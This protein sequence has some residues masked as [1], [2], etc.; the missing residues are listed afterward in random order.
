VVNNRNSI[1]EAINHARLSPQQERLWK[2]QQ[3][4]IGQPYRTYCAIMIETAVDRVALKCSIQETIARHQALNTCFICSADS[5]YPQPTVSPAYRPEISEH[6]LS[7]LPQDRRKLRVEELTDQIKSAAFDYERGHLVH[8]ALLV[9]SPQKTLIVLCC[10]A[11]A[12]DTRSLANLMA[13]IWQCYNEQEILQP[14]VP[15]AE[16]A[17]IFQ[18]LL[19]SA[20]T[21]LGRS[22]WTDKQPGHAS[23]SLPF[24]VHS[25]EA[26]EFN[27]QSLQVELDSF[28]LQNIRKMAEASDVSVEAVLL[29]CWCLVLAL[30]SDLEDLQIGLGCDGRTH[31]SLESII[32][33]C[34]RVVPLQLAITP[35]LSVK[36]LVFEVQT[37]INEARQWQDYFG[38]KS[39]T[40]QPAFFAMS[41]DYQKWLIGNAVVEETFSLQTVASYFDP[42]TVKLSCI[43]TAQKLILQFHYDI[44]SLNAENMGR[45][46]RYYFALLQH[47]AAEPRTSIGQL[48]LLPEAER[49]QLLCEFGC[50]IES[51]PQ[52]GF[53]HQY[54]EQQ[55]ARTP[56]SPALL[57]EST[58]LSYCELN[59][60]ANQ[61]ARYLR[62]LGAGVESIIGIFLEPSLEMAIAVL[63]VLK[64]GAAYLPL[65]TA[66]PD[67]RLWLMLEDAGPL[68]VL[69]SSVQANRLSQKAN[70]VVLDEKQ[71]KDTLEQY[72]GEN[73]ALQ[74]ASAL[75]A[76]NLS[77]VIYTSG[78]TGLPKGVMIE[79]AALS[80][81]FHAIGEEIKFS[82]ADIQLWL[83]T[84]SFDISILELLF[85][86]C[87]GARVVI[88][89]KDDGVNPSTMSRLITTSGVTS[90][91]STPSRWSLLIEEKPECLENIRILCGG[92]VLTRKLAKQ[93]CRMAK[94]SLFNLYGPTEATIWAALHKLGQ[95][96]LEGDDGATIAIGRALANCNLYV[97]DSRLQLCPVGV[98]GELYIG[99]EQLARGYI[100]RPELTAARFIP[101]PFSG[102]G[103]RMYRT[104]D[105]ACWNSNGA[106]QFL[107]RIDDQI[108]IRGFRIE[109]AEIESV[110]CRHPAIA[111]AV[112]IARDGDAG[113]KQLVAYLVT[114]EDTKGASREHEAE[115]L[116]HWSCLFEEIARQDPNALVDEDFRIWKSSYDAEAIPLEEMREWRSA[117]V[118]RILELHPQNL[119]EIG[120]GSGLILRKVATD[121]QS[122]W[123]TDFSKSTLEKLQTV[124]AGD[125]V[126]RN[127]VRLELR[128]AHDTEGLPTDFFDVIALNSVIQ[129]FPSAYYLVE[130]LARLLAL[131][132]SGG[133][134]FLGDVRNL[135]LH[136]CFL[137][138]L[139][140]RKAKPGTGALELERRVA[141][142]MAQE[143]ELL[144]APE[145]FA[146]LEDVLPEIGAVDIQ[147]KRGWSHNE[148]TRYRYE[149]VLHKKP[150][151]TYSAREVISFSWE[152]DVKNLAGLEQLLMVQ[153]M[154]ELR[155]AGVPNARTKQEFTVFQALKTAKDTDQLRDML[156]STS[157]REAV[158]PEAICELGQKL[159]YRVAITWSDTAA[160]TGSFDVLLIRSAEIGTAQFTHL[161]Q[162][163]S[164]KSSS[165]A[166]YAN[167][168]S[169][170]DLTRD[171]VLGIQKH[172]E[173]KLPNYMIPSAI[174][175]LPRLPLTPNG[176]I[177]RAALEAVAIPRLNAFLAPQ[178][179]TEHT[180]AQ[181]WI[182][183]LGIS[184]PSIE[185]NFF[186]LGG[187]S[188]LSVRII[189]RANR[190]GLCLVP[191]D[192]FEYPT[193][194]SL[195]TVAESRKCDSTSHVI[196]RGNEQLPVQEFGDSDFLLSP[197]AKDLLGR[198]EE[199]IDAYPLS[200]LQQ[201]ILFDTQLTED[202]AAYVEQ[203][204]YV[205]RGDF[206]L[207]AFKL[208]WT[209][210][211]DR[212]PIFRTA[213]IW[214]ETLGHLQTVFREI[215]PFWEE[216]DWTNLSRDEQSEQFNTFLAQDRER[217][218]DL[219]KAPLF[220]L[221]ILHLGFE[222]RQV[223]LTIHHLISDGWSRVIL[224]NE[225]FTFY[226]SLSRAGTIDL[227]AAP[228]Y[229]NY[230][231]WLQQQDMEKAESFWRSVL[232]GFTAPISIESDLHP[233]EKETSRD[234]MVQHAIPDEMALALQSF[235]ARHKLTLSTLV[236]GAWALLLSRHADV[237]DVVF[238]M[239]VSG[240]PAALPGIEGII[241]PFINT[242]PVRIIV[243]EQE[244]VAEWLTRLQNQQASAR[245]YQFTP[246]SSIQNWSV[247]RPLFKTLVVVEN[248]PVDNIVKKWEQ[249]LNIEEAHNFVGVVYPLVLDVV[250]GNLPLLLRLKYDVGLFS[251]ESI[252][253]LLAEFQEILERFMAHPHGSLVEITRFQSNAG[254][255]TIPETSDYSGGDALEEFN[256]Q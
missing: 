239:T 20:D 55:A 164:V 236:Q 68:L 40:A 93:L 28:T 83:T 199:I 12:V 160:E 14:P 132:A 185:D 39:D 47:L 116:E 246:L 78:S 19:E 242:L 29:T 182:E 203:V 56:D 95:E 61:L 127:R 53:V 146:A 69:S 1:S 254:L 89:K 2:L 135:H 8:A 126:L 166:D 81:F 41:F 252:R 156:D 224:L 101:D 7:A 172:L 10:A 162:G 106:L 130:V 195:A 32:G 241:G 184:Q 240:R 71:F 82:P 4:L 197:A 144:L 24:E 200:P 43:E 119:L 23:S 143:P 21:E 229:R 137:T 181:I 110:L 170:L 77:Y 33:P 62:T 228:P 18:E 9:L 215:P 175:P 142:A 111:Q 122:Y 205:I 76:H 206:H 64:S 109:L 248:Y 238:G 38:W 187:D 25:S 103:R 210:I 253:A 168:P 57:Y 35:A 204:S 99:G 196:N 225:L 191:K 245:E 189:A 250:G 121:C 173:E 176:K 177:D 17:Q 42:F 108:K 66:Q 31:E 73:P 155:I 124:V 104:G 220:R 151:A 147:L 30:L 91:Q 87:Y 233:A 50:R 114:R 58:A 244:P 192:L 98:A 159:G 201:G 54:F 167:H 63:A 234:G 213:F 243:H 97:L 79:H 174:I 188:I 145:F 202:P 107:Q 152:A 256:F 171:L 45:V 235:G 208:A 230:I 223:V 3:C 13:E 92:E 219:G 232:K 237:K 36:D 11:L 222:M 161:Y 60:K 113:Q 180:L 158:E 136:Q 46:S 120:T 105:R 251:T 154:P 84:L 37:K 22:H 141:K 255:T 86:L 150:I 88:A 80:S 133:H 221:M 16:I 117:A 85:P 207:D 112:V 74:S 75:C 186:T 102:T 194:R 115:Q 153:R 6:D 26:A 231:A 138:A 15:Y 190:V 67:A 183:V 226:D 49:N 212:H 209:R 178:T 90:V 247:I 227:P 123:G 70:L 163:K 118:A 198:G 165:L 148:L 125:S 100:N 34:M 52:N 96:D 179:E 217:G 214:N 169:A 59:R 134:I 193:I 139:E 129:Y 27:P 249:L 128:H 149:V 5:E 131:L 94:G 65:D 140:V 51:Y 72:S 48:S 211:V 44:S 157:D 216:R 218:F